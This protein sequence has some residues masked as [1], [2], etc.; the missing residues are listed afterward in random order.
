[1]NLG[2]H[3]AAPG[4]WPLGHTTQFSLARAGGAVAGEFRAVRRAEADSR[5]IG[6]RW[7]QSR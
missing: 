1:M 5:E 3:G 7:S 2:M 6:V 4:A